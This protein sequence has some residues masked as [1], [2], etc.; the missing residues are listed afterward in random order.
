MAEPPAA[1]TAVHEEPEY[2]PDARRQLFV[3]DMLG[4]LAGTLIAIAL[5]RPLHIAPHLGAGAHTATIALFV[6]FNA[7]TLVRLGVSGQYDTG[8]RFSRIDDVLVVLRSAFIGVC[9]SV[10]IA[11]ATKGFFTGFE[12]Y[13]RA[14]VALALG[15]PT[16]LLIGSRLAGHDMQVAA[17]RSGRYLARS[18]VVG[19]E[20][21]AR[22]FLDWLEERPHL[23]LHGRL[24]VVDIDLPLRDYMERFTAELAE[25][26]PDE[27]ILALET[28]QGELRQAIVRD[29]TF[30]GINVKVLPAVFENYYDMPFPRYEGVPV[31]TIYDSAG[32]RFAR[33][34]KH[35]IDRAGS[36]VGLLVLSPLLALIA[37][38]VWLEDRGPVTFAQERVGE[39]G[40]LF[41]VHKFRTM[42]IDAEQRL[43]ALMDQ[44]EAQGPM[45][46]MQHDPRV[47]R[48]GRVLR[49]TSLDELPQLWNVLFGEMSLV[50]PRPPIPAEVDQY[51]V[52]HRRRLLARPGMTGLWQV[53]GRSGTTFDEMVALDLLYIDNWSFWLDAKILLRTVAV[54]LG[55]SGA[56]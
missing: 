27:I 23:G 17:F 1:R 20:G 44:N 52:A 30:K 33:Q 12:G 47:T 29:A 7:V 16:V 21:R 2:A 38:A 40:S 4:M 55:R 37:L 41:R 6:V 26:E 53:S 19:R 54:V 25:F 3:A 28:G 5:H 24:S 43:A 13:S 56:Y 50:G 51:Q 11:V 35:G 49:R 48:V 46:K 8:E 15:L 10:T 39:R 9:V 42:H 22:E 45:F 31:T 32:R 36:L 34:L 18:L 14:Y